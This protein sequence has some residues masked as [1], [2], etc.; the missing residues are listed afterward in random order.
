MNDPFEDKRGPE[1][2]AGAAFM[3]SD[4]S[5]SERRFDHITL[6]NSASTSAVKQ[7]LAAIVMVLAFIITAAA[8]FANA[9]ANWPS[10]GEFAERITTTNFAAF[11][12]LV[13]CVLNLTWLI[14]S[15]IG[16]RVSDLKSNRLRLILKR[17][18]LESRLKGDAVSPFDDDLSLNEP[19]IE[20]HLKARKALG[21]EA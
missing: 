4:Q 6:Q 18:E 1:D 17:Q 10:V 13:I 15:I 3:I 12:V 16:R 5:S 19:L 2:I 11:V 21:D 9:V 8:L 14:R 7:V 20:Q